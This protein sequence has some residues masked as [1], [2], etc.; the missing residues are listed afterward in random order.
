MALSGKELLETNDDDDSDDEN[1][2]QLAL[3]LVG[4]PQLALSHP[5]ISQGM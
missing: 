3:L 4:S 1:K 5:V 2:C